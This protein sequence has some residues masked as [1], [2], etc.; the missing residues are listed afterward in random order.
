MAEIRKYADLNSL[1]K[2]VDEIAARYVSGDDMAMIIEEVVNITNEMCV[3]FS[4]QDNA[5]YRV[6]LA[7]ALR[8]GFSKS[9][10]DIAWN[11]DVASTANAANLFK[12]RSDIVHFPYVDM[13]GVMNL[14]AAFMDCYALEE[15]APQLDFSN[16]ERAEYMFANCGSLRKLDQ[17]I[18]PNCKAFSYMFQQCVNLKVLPP[19]QTSQAEKMD[20]MFAYCRKLKALPEGLELG[21]GLTSAQMLC[22]RCECLEEVDLINSGESVENYWRAFMGCTS[23]K[24]L[25]LNVQSATSLDQTF[26]ECPKLAS[27]VLY[28]LGAYMRDIDLTTLKAWGDNSI[29]PTAIESV[30]V[31]L[32]MLPELITNMGERGAVTLH[33]DVMAR[34]KEYAGD[35]FDTLIAKLSAQG[36]TV[37]C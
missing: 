2:L 14:Y 15:L 18:M 21:V 16:V 37:T 10:A 23:L 19:M 20:G 11:W 5:I 12:G 36:W 3:T 1:Q 31:T 28:G 4:A 32:N 30:G 26:N 34:F 17:L 22:Y 29:Y 13:S 7:T 25:G 6:T 35:G 24:V 27:V 9:E 33:P 8:S